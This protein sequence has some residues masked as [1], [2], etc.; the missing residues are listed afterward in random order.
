MSLEI[1]RDFLTKVA[2][3][4]GFRKGLVGCTTGAEQQFARAAGF[5][6]T[7]EEIRAAA[8]ELQDVD[9]DVVSGGAFCAISEC[10]EKSDY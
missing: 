7:R 2:K 6:F 8:G 5:E 3:D 10:C 4:E 9:L 1:A